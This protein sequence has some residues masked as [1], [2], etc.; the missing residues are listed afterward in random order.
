MKKLLISVSTGC[1]L[2]AGT[3]TVPAISSTDVAEA[4]TVRYAETTAGVN[5]RTAPSTSSKV[6]GVLKK[7]TRVEVLEVVNSNWVK[8][9]Y[10][11]H[12]GYLSTKYLKEINS[13]ANGTNNNT[14]NTQTSQAQGSVADRVIAN[15]QKFSGTKYEF[16]A[17]AGQ[18][19]TFDC[20]SFVQYLF[21]Q[22][23][24]NLPRSSR[25]QSQVGTTVSSFSNLQ[26]GD[27]VFF[28]TA[29]GSQIDHV[30]IYMG[31]NKILHT[32]PNGGVQVSNFTGY[33]KNTAVSAKRVIK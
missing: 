32:I 20:S 4:A 7:G 1:L 25:Q 6:L 2:L 27:L 5:F 11:N 19:K 15:G 10:S 14:S 17:K 33:W 26:K 28:K 8:A 29:G 18:T 30:A 31:D 23:G 22:E 13:S 21:K 9:K 24:I 12:T 3:F 16:G